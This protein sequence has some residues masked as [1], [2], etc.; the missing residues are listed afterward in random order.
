MV[1]TTTNSIENATIEKY[2][3]V[4][5]T[6]LVIGTGFFSD[7]TAALTDFFGGMSGTY[8]RQMDE[9]YQKAYDALSLKA[10]TL[11]ANGVLGFKIDFDEISG[12]GVQMFMI[13]VSGTAVKL[14]YESLSASEGE[15]VSDSVSSELVNIEVFKLNWKNRSKERTP[16]SSVLNFI[17]DNYLWELAPSLY[18]YYTT[19]N[20]AIDKR[21]IDERFPIILSI[22]PYDTA[23]QFIYNEYI[24]F[25]K[26]AYQL[27]KEN[28]LFCPSKVLDILR[29]GNL[30]EG[31]NLLDTE[32]NAYTHEDLKY[33]ESI[34]EVLDNL[35]DKGQIT[36]VKAGAFSSK[37]V[38]V[39]I[40]PLGHKNDRDTEYCTHGN[41]IP[42][43]GLNIKGLKQEQVQLINAFRDRVKVIKDL[44]K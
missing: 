34:M 24:K 20:Y 36:E 1:I 10:S 43:C 38:E 21:P 11:G 2:L 5:T 9:L 31:I 17:M 6:N 15:A 7:F 33:M 27:I 35:P 14:K 23:V 44:L 22:L 26:Y 41:T 25:E 19:P 29:E 16:M 12:K 3:G 39:Y 40:C 32:K 4:V 28:K 30:E 8:R 37:M 42:F 13:S 18:E